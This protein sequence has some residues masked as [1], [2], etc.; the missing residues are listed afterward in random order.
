MFWSRSVHSALRLRL[1]PSQHVY[2]AK[3]D[4]NETLRYLTWLAFAEIV[5]PPE[6]QVIGKLLAITH[7]CRR[8]TSVRAPDNAIYA[9]LFWA[10]GVWKKCERSGAQSLTS[11]ARRRGPR[12][13]YLYSCAFKCV[14]SGWLVQGN[15][16]RLGAHETEVDIRSGAERNE[17][18]HG[19]WARPEERHPRE[20]SLSKSTKS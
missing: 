11:P 15:D 20:V 10:H 14:S 1:E 18:R 9:L 7:A 3:L 17:R 4:L 13:Q 6:W 16:G 8:S 19:W 2:V 12:L 5:L